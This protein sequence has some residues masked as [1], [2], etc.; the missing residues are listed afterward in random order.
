VGI[1]LVLVYF[2]YGLS[3]FAMGMATLLETGR[4]LSTGQARSLSW[5]SAFGLIHGTH[6]WLEAYLLQAQAIGTPLPDSLSWIRLGL[7][8]SS[9]SSLFVYAVLSLRQVSADFADRSWHVLLPILWGLAVL[10]SAYV[11]YRSVPTPPWVNLIDGISRYI[12]AVP[13]AFLAFISLRANARAAAKDNRRPVAASLRLAAIGFGAYA[14]TQV[15]VH[16]LQFFPASAINL[17]TFMSVTGLPIQA[18]RA[19]TALLIAVGTMRAAQDLERER[20][21]ELKAADRARL[22]AVEERDA[23]RRDLLV[24][25]VRSQEDERARIARELHDEI[26]QLLSAFSL[27]L[28]A[29]RTKL[30]RADTTER[31]DHLQDIAR[32]MSQGL[33][34]LV[35]DLRPSH[36][37]N[38]GLVPA[39]GFLLSQEYRP[40]GMDVALEV[41]GVP[42]PMG[43]LAETALFRVAQE[44]LANTVR[45]ARVNR[46]SVALHFDPARVT[47][48]I[49][50]DGCGFDPNEA[51]H[52]PRG[53]GLAGMRERVESLSGKLDIR[54]APGSGTTVEVVLPLYKDE[55]K[56]SLDGTH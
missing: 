49:S 6:E 34:H 38:L 44:A 30:K 2:V 54:S 36:L 3:F 35:S 5:L 45:H 55:G 10:V 40:K 26:A 25:V 7:L 50:D 48:Q 15:F 12:L 11:S 23:L 20:Q 4:A 14:L 28:A 53:W 52:P 18:L 56:E 22:A 47:L 29:L 19:A 51:F 8:I 13:A 41:T 1:E 32:Q 24:H 17:E 9:F 21:A 43:P 33:Y 37:D 46:A 27:E 31:I 39:L 42:R 16:R